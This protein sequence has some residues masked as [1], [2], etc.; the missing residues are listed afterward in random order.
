MV[1]IDKPCLV[2]MCVRGEVAL[3]TQAITEFLKNNAFWLCFQS[4]WINIAVTK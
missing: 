3:L 1:I 2:W 4:P